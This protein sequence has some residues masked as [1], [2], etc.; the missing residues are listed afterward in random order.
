MTADALGGVFL[1]AAVLLTLYT[2]A[3]YPALLYVVSSL[4]RRTVPSDDPDQWPSVSVSLPAHNEAS[5]IGET[6]EALLA[7]D[8][9]REKLQIVVVSD[10]SDD[11]TDEVVRSFSDRGVE[12]VR[13]DARGGKEA[14]ENAAAH[15]LRG[16]IVLNMDATSRVMQPAIKALVRPFSDPEIGVV[17]GRDVSV[18]EGD[19]EDN[20][21]ERGYTSME[22]WL[23]SRETR[24]CSV[25]G[26]S[27][28]LYAVRRELHDSDFPPGFNRDFA[29]ALRARKRGFRSVS[30]DEAQVLVPVTGSP[31]T[32]FRR[33]VRTILRGLSTLVWQ[34]DLLNPV[35]YGCFSWILLS[36]KLCRWLVPPALAAGWLGLCL[37]GLGHP[38][39]AAAA[40]GGLAAA[41]LGVAGLY[42]RPASPELGRAWQFWTFAVTT[43]LAV[44]VAWARL[45]QGRRQAVWSP[46]RRQGAEEPAGGAESG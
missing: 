46:T 34:K 12:L 15:R 43:Q 37:L 6:L 44:L 26:A 8:Y 20:P 31:L 30:A 29:S 22:M 36:H 23:R 11:G 35:R 28:C 39:A 1:L 41:A 24:F 27:G 18:A 7:A 13:V 33:K 19:R 17:S 32:E 3:G 4:R 45:F 10:A 38:P 16:E 40:G 21:G 25:V 14:A 5:A 42:W 2:Y 9:P